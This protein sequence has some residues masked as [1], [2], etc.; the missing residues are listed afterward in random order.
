MR[1]R[2]GETAYEVAGDGPTVV[3]V[4]GLGLRRQ[5]W[6]WQLPALVPHFTVISYDLLGHGE[7]ADPEGSCNLSLFADQ[8]ARLLDEIGVERCAAVGFSLGGMIV[9]AFALAYPQR[10]SRRAYL[11]QNVVGERA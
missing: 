4:H 5:M 11:L 9:R 3:L 1:T 2:S 8:L 7:S 10:A 6:Q